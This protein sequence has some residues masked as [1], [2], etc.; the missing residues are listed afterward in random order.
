MHGNKGIECVN[1]FMHQPWHYVVPPLHTP[2]RNIPLNG[3]RYDE[4]LHPPFG[5]TVRLEGE[6][7]RGGGEELQTFSNADKTI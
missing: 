6:R 1:A 7:R 5:A 4:H 2:P 3:C